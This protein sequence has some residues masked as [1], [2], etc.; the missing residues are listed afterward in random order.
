MIT[1]LIVIVTV[2]DQLTKWLVQRYLDFGSSVT[3]IPGLFD[4]SKV[5]NRG[6]AWGMLSGQRVI[7]VAVSA[8]ML[9]FLWLNR[10]EFLRGGRIERIGVGLLAGGIIGNLID[11]VKLGYVIDF[12]DFHW[13]TYTFPTFNVADSAICVGV[14]LFVVCQFF[15]KKATHDHE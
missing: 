15:G 7:L 4:F 3:I 1:G 8:L 14:A 12:L 5:Y 11:R 2:L 10:K 9:G 13:G 6:A